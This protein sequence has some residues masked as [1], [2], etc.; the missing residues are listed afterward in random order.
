M[1]MRRE[2]EIC[3][4]WG[5]HRA[6]LMRFARLRDQDEPERLHHKDGLSVA[7]LAGQINPARWRR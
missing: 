5:G 1:G 3:V 2:E 7:P 4:G 6:Y